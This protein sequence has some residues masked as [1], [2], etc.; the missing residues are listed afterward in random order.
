MFGIL[1][2]LL[3]ASPIQVTALLDPF[4]T[5]QLP[6]LLQDRTPESVCEQYNLVLSNE[7]FTENTLT[8]DCVTADADI[9][10]DCQYDEP[11]CNTENNSTAC[12]DGGFVLSMD[13]TGRVY[14]NL[15]CF[16]ETTSTDVEQNTCVAIVTD[17]DF[18][19]VSSCEASLNDEPCTSC[20]I[21]ESDD[22]L[23]LNCSNVIEDRIQSECVE[24]GTN[25]AFSPLYDRGEDEGTTGGGSPNGGGGTSLAWKNSLQLGWMMASFVL[26]SW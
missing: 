26:I 24:V 12:I 21:C 20:D 11:I 7:N 22:A 1:V 5:L 16:N 14:R 19:T 2:L 10:I 15:N 9:I 13:A 4:N 3:V 17:N 25:G 6:R 18:S 23:T 8:C